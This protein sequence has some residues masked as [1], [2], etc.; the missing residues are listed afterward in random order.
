MKTNF[1]RI[2]AALLLLLT[3]A[4]AGCTPAAEE[5]PE[6]RGTC[7][8]GICLSANK[9]T[10]Q[11]GGEI[12]IQSG[13]TLDLQSGA[14]TDFSGGIDLDGAAIT[15]SADGSTTF[16]STTDD[17]IT[18]TIGASTGYLVVDTGNLKVGNGT[19]TVTLNGEDLYVNGTAEVDGT[20]YADGD[21]DV[22]G[23][24]TANSTLDVDGAV[25][26][27]S[28]LDVDGAVTLNSTVDID[29]NI[30]SGTGFV[31]VTDSLIVDGQ[32]DAVQF[33]LQGHSSQTSDL[34]VAETSAGL[35]KF[36]IDGS[37]NTEIA[38][39]LSM[40]GSIAANGGLTV[41]STAF[42]VEDTSGNVRTAGT[43]NSYGASKF[44]S[45]VVTGTLDVSGGAT[46]NSTMDIDG[47]ITSGTGAITMTDNVFIDGLQDAIQLLVQGHSTQTSN[48]FVCETSAGTDVFT[49]TN[50]G[51][52]DAA[53]TLQYGAN[54]LY[55]LGYGSS[56]YQV[57][58]G[59]NN[60]TGALRVTHG[61]TTPSWGSCTLGFSPSV[62]T[63][64][65]CAVTMAGAVVT[66]SV[67]ISTTL[68]GAA[69]PIYWQVIGTP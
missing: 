50:A 56:G 15:L 65:V 31:T 68:S 10:V 45:T 32:A 6:A 51:N 9:L 5:V 33:T 64:T 42:V 25:T 52:V 69:A 38:G 35:D 16:G 46:F 22:D 44:A 19:P 49:V 30:T 21:L 23:A 43:L 13:A 29:G 11:S 39:T 28:T 12:E 67:Y 2:A 4:L 62:V 17:I 60:I 47:A 20:L 18:A 57:V 61:L 1:W 14:T 63:G 41:D 8:A 26:A 34:F 3:A 48:L 40:T 66:V 7:E 53:G 54:N 24:V 55:P 59:N 36:V 27:N 37:G 58:V